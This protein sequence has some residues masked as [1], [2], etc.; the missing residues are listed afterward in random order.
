MI[1]LAQGLNKEKFSKKV[2][3]LVS[4]EAT[5][6][7]AIITIKDRYELSEKDVPRLLD[8]D[9]KVELEKEMLRLKMIENEKVE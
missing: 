1:N 3:V 6:L 8:E 4:R 2:R 7:D 5:Y 9:I